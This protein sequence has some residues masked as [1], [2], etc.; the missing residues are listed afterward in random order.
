IGSVI[1]TSDG[2]DIKLAE[3]VMA[4]YRQLQAFLF[5]A[6]YKNPRAK[7]EEYK[8]RDIVCRLYEYYSKNPDA[9]PE[10]N[11]AVVEAEGAARAAVDYVASM[12]DRYCVSVYT[13]L[14]VPKPWGY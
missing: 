6:V 9:L 7:G 8:A 1:E 5:E 12:S 13:D 14:F 2:A 4:G 10:D 11:K 3:D